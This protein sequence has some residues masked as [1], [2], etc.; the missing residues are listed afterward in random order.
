MSQNPGPEPAL[1]VL[2]PHLD[3]AVLSCAG[4][5]STLAPG[6]RVRVV[7]F[8]TEAAAGP[9]TRA[10]RSFLR[11]AGWSGD[12]DA[13]YR[14]RRGE[15]REAVGRLGAAW[16]H[17]GLVD[18]L[19][20]SRQGWAPGGVGD[21]FAGPVRRVLPEVTYRYPSYRYDI[22]RGRVSRADR[23]LRRD[24][25]ERVARLLDELHP[26]AVLAPLGVGRH[27]DHLLVRDAAV[28]ALA[29][30]AAA[31][32]PVP[33]GGPVGGPALFGGSAP[34]G[35]SAD[36]PAPAPV[37]VFYADLPYAL[38][39]RPD[40][41]FVTINRLRRAEYPHGA[42][43]RAVLVGLYRTQAGALFPAGVPTVVDEYWWQEG[44][45]REGILARVVR[46]SAS[47]ARPPRWRDPSSRP[48]GPGLR[49]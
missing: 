20:R 36:G 11:Q 34:A 6:V 32:M 26:L 4:L 39:Q 17:V 40:P 42:E 24:L 5:L 12:P 38:R 30:A 29:D 15:D 8:F 45:D 44:V 43:Q 9:L 13:F 16:T 2:S 28:T 1:L 21:R 27:V 19:F 49:R 35:G 25:T 22:A 37:P 33:A 31:A 3:D 48:R 7:T 14:Q 41:E 46:P 23:G 18:A 10:A 47:A